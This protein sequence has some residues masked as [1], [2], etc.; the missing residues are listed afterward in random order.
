MNVAG[1]SGVRPNNRPSRYRVTAAAPAMPIAIPDHGQHQALIQHQPHDFRTLR[2]ERH[3]DADLACPLSDRVRHHAVNADGRQGHADAGED[4]EQDGVH[5]RAGDPIGHD[6]VHRG[7]VVGRGLVVDLADDGPDGRHDL[8]E[9]SQSFGPGSTGRAET[10]E[11]RSPATA[12]RP[13][14]TAAPEPGR[15]RTAGRRE[16][17]RRFPTGH[18]RG[19]APRAARWGPRRQTTSGPGLR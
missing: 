17:L 12:G 11:S 13:R 2:A 7:D 15:A 19:S 10:T 3:A 1:S 5:A 4:A 9:I 8:H 18:R 14:T 6:V 16:P